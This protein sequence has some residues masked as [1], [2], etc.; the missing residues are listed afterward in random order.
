MALGSI[1][2]RNIALDANY[3]STRSALW[4]ATVYLHLYN[5]NPLSGGLELTL[6]TGGYEPIAIANTNTSWNA[7]SNGQKTNKATFA[8]AASTAAWSAPATWWW[9]GDAAKG[10]TIPGIPTVTPEGT[11]GTTNWQYVV[12]ARNA[13][14]ETRASGIGVTTIGYSLLSTTNYNRVTWTAVATATSYNVYRK[15][16]TTFLKIATAVATTQ[17]TDKGAATTTVS[18]PIVNGTFNL[19]DGGPLTQS[20]KVVAAGYAISFPPGTIVI[21]QT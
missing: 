2:A 17:Y 3:G 7:A 1:K 4:P 15:H 5:L 13:I 18:P 11:T 14:G 19:L 8:F 16:N 10:L 12:T 20:I 21:T 9:L 6:G